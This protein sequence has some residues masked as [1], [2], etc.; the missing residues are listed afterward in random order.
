MAY[1]LHIICTHNHTH[2]IYHCSAPLQHRRQTGDLVDG[3]GRQGAVVEGAGVLGRPC[4]VGKP[5][6]NAVN[7][8][9]T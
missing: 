5:W 9:K 2:L 1:Y 4:K 6:E 3:G 8:G 7:V